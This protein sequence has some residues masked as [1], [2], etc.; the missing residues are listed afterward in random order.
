[1]TK[2]IW[3]NLVIENGA[4]KILDLYQLQ[5]EGL[6]RGLLIYP[7]T[8]NPLTLTIKRKKEKK[9]GRGLSKHITTPC[10]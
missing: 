10:S 9:Q 3:Y 5:M 8:L 2:I 6:K 1:M 4:H 7:T